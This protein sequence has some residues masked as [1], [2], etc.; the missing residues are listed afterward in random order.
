MPNK[1]VTELQMKKVITSL[2][3]LLTGT[4]DYCSQA[5]TL[6]HLIHWQTHSDDKNSEIVQSALIQETVRQHYLTD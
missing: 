6:S 2:M 1:K 5:E 4:I 3:A